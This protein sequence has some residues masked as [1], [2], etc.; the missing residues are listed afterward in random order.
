MVTHPLTLDGNQL[1][2]P[3]QKTYIATKSFSEVRRS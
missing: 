2:C 1:M 3:E